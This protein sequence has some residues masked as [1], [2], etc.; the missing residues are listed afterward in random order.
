[1]NTHT[2]AHLTTASHSRF[3]ELDGLRGLAALAVVFAHFEDAASVWPGFDFG[4]YG[5]Q[6][7]FLISG[8]VILLSAQAAH[9]PIDFVISRITRL[10]PAYWFS[11]TLATLIVIVAGLPVAHDPLTVLINIS[12]FQRWLLV[13]NIDSVYWTLAVELQF[14]VLVAVLLWTRRKYEVR[15]PASI[16]SYTAAAWLTVSL[17]VAL[18]SSPTSHGIDPQLVPTT[19]KVILNLTIAEYAPLFTGGAFL[20]LSRTTGRLHPMVFVAWIGSAATNWLIRDEIHAIIT[21]AIFGL[22]ILV[23][24]RGKTRTLLLPPIQWYGKISYSLYLNHSLMLLAIVPP[25]L[26]TIGPIPTIATSLVLVTLQSWAVWQLGEKRL[27]PA[28]RKAWTSYL[29]S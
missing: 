23:T 19:T 2:P 3:R 17:A 6:L 28:W 16:L 1:M 5:V 24:M 20:Y 15:L 10:Y 29:N 22:F 9:R 26:A 27:S 13:D 25:L 8:F 14:Y 7:F 11:L 18:W 21:P 12:M 4:V